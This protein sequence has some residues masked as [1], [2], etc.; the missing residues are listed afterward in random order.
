MWFGHVQR[1]PPIKPVRRVNCMVFKAV[2][3]VE[4]DQKWHTRTLLK[5]ILK[6]I[7]EVRN[8]S[9]QA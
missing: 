3:G 6:L 8:M 5:R 9:H 2:K 1:R 4:G 7:K